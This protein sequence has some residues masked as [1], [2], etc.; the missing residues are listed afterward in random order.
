MND[1]IK[2][3]IQNILQLRL[4]GKI[5]DILDILNVVDE[6]FNGSK[7]IPYEVMK[8]I[9]DRVEELLPCDNIPAAKAKYGLTIVC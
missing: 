4:D 8:E 5:N 2:P 1:N 6:H 7:F 9:T 3:L